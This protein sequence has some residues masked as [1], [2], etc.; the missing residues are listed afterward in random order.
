MFYGRAGTLDATCRSHGH[1]RRPG[2]RHAEV[3][4]WSH[5]RCDG[6]ACG[7][8]PTPGRYAECRDARTGLARH[9]CVG[10]PQREGRS[11][12]RRQDSLGLQAG[13][14]GRRVAAS[15]YA[16]LPTTL[17]RFAPDLGWCFPRVRAAAARARD[18]HAHGRYVREVA[19]NGEQGGR[20][21][22]RTRGAARGGRGGRKRIRFRAKW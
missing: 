4:P 10:V 6:A 19:P 21:P 18:L 1:R 5:G 3:G 22:R 14:P 20:P 2:A 12:G 9:A 16:A 7:R 13:P 15:L 11:A 8:A 17:L